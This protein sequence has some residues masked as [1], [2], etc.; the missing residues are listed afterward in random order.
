MCSYGKLTRYSDR[1]CMSSLIF[2]HSTF[3]RVKYVSPDIHSN[4]TIQSG[5]AQFRSRS[6]SLAQHLDDGLHHLAL[7][8]AL[9]VW[10]P[11]GP[12]EV[13]LSFMIFSLQTDSGAWNVAQLALDIWH[14]HNLRWDCLRPYHAFHARNVCPSISLFHY[15]NCLVYSCRSACTIV[16]WKL[17]RPH[18]SSLI[19]LIAFPYWAAWQASAWRV[20]ERLGE[21]SSWHGLTSSGA[22]ISWVSSFLRSVLL[23]GVW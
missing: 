3:K 11:C 17:S 7:P 21:I 1:A 6:I 9:L 8:I 15:S 16:I 5:V 23:S 22:R 2:S 18:H 13:H 10:F 12:C 14:R 19:S 20:T 4:S